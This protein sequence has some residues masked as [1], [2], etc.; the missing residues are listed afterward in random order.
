MKSL[1]ILFLLF[2]TL[3]LNAEDKKKLIYLNPDASIPFWQ[4]MTKGVDFSAKK[5]GYKLEIFSAYNSSK[6]E[7][8]NLVKAIKEKPLGLIISPTNSFQCVT[9]LRLA[10]KANIPVIIS[11]IGTNSGEYVSFI[12]SDNKKGAYKIGQVLTRIMNEKGLVDSSVGIIS[13]PQKRTNGKLRTAGF[14]KALKENKIKT[15]DIRQQI[16]FS[17]EE[18]YTYSKELIKDNPNMKALWLQGS[19]KYKGALKAIKES[20]KEILLLTFDAEP[21][22]LDLIPQDILVGA[23]MQQPFLMGEKAVET[24]DKYLKG[25]KVEKNIQLPILAISKENIK[26]ELPLIKRNVL[27]LTVEK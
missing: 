20:E 10:K 15:A 19:D 7:L 26:K 11:D 2:L 13:I 22:F 9:L 17:L 1:K 12:S 16:D 23:A 27:G 21:E 8:E 25:K 3:H 18:T 4:I 24:L 14:L 5:L 6:K